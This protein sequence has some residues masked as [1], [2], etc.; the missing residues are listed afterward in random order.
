MGDEEQNEARE[1]RVEQ[2]R[3]KIERGEE[4]TEEE[5]DYLRSEG[6]ELPTEE[7]TAPPAV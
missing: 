2:I 3:A 1:E 5:K 6:V 4:P 7:G